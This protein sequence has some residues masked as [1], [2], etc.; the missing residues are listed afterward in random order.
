MQTSASETTFYGVGRRLLHLM[1]DVLV[2]VDREGGTRVTE[3]FG[4]GRDRNAFESEQDGAGV[5]QIV[6]TR[7]RW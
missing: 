1:D 2:V 7:P 4:D 3:H 6:Q 5:P